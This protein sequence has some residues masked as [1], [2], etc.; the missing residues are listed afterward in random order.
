MGLIEHPE[1]PLDDPARFPGSAIDYARRYKLE[2][3]TGIGKSQI[4][5]ALPEEL[6]KGK[7][8][9]IPAGWVDRNDICG[10]VCDCLI[11]ARMAGLL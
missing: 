8:K 2:F 1:R 4:K 7:P 6:W 11:T 10:A 5:A 9:Y 3:W